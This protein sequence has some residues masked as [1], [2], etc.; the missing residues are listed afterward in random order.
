LQSGVARVETLDLQVRSGPW[1]F[2]LEQAREIERHWQ[3]RVSGNPTFFNGT[4][5]LLTKHDLSGSHFRGEL[6]PVS[7]ASFLYWRDNDFPDKTVR[8][9]FG[10][11]LLRSQ[12]GTVVLGRQAPGNINSGKTYLPGGFIDE[13][14][15]LESGNV[16]LHASVSRELKEELGLDHADLAIGPHIY[17]T[18]DEQLLSLALE[19]RSPDDAQTLL[20]QATAHIGQE[21]NPE[22][23]AVIGINTAQD[24][25]GLQ[26]PGYARLLLEHLL[27]A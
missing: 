19:Y 1:P 21:E 24:L 25:Q 8:D 18:F 23:E 6:I 11:A 14:D 16:D 13:R 4:V 17:L 15:V 5:H 26:M 7:F 3:N 27:P 2:A 22:L 10:S 20:A 9:C 12:E